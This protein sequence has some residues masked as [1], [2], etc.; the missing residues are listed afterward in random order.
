MNEIESGRNELEEIIGR[1]EA[2]KNTN[3]M[4]AQLPSALESI[5]SHVA[6]ING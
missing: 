1:L 5:M 4:R 6:S 3:P 2:Y